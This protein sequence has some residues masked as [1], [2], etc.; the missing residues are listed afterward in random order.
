M[1][2]KHSA[3]FYKDAY[4][5]LPAGYASID[6]FRQSIRAG[7]KRF[8]L[9]A[10]RE[11]N[12]IHSWPIE[13][14]VCI[15]PYFYSEYG[16]MEADAVIDDAQ[17]VYPV[18]V[19]LFTQSEYNE[20]LRSVILAFCPGCLRYKPLTER[21]QSLNGHFHEIALN[22]V[23]FCRQ[24]SKPAPRVFRDNLFSLGGC[25]HRSDPCKAGAES[26]RDTI[27]TWTY[28]KYTSA[29]KPEGDP[30]RL[31]VSFKPDFFVQMLSNVLARYI[32]TALTFTGFRLLPDQSTQIDKN[33]FEAQL[34]QQ[35]REVFRKNC[36][37]YGV[38]L[39][40]LRFDPSRERQV[41]DVLE[42]LARQY[43][44]AVLY[45]EKGIRYLAL[46]DE[47]KTRKDLHYR[48]PLLEAAE[49]KMEIFDQYGD[50]QYRITFKMEQ[51]R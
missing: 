39:S 5:L 8:R 11:D 18:E 3:F 2:E 24:E 28:L 14:G 17:E 33:S 6:E 27:G 37:K 21:V 40:I 51:C 13:K 38:A 34:S 1:S 26:I 23:C 16:F 44:F 42:A 10:L 49:A 31:R 25:W 43:D 36:R 30:G 29:E 7:Q 47:S 22:S 35:N 19:E 41:A 45:R 48:A 32:E 9:Q 15:A 46:L 4:W 50:R 12:K 20:R